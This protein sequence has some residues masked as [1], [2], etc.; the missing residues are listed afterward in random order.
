MATTLIIPL[1]CEPPYATGVALEKAKRQKKKK[2]KKKKK[3]MNNSKMMQN[4]WKEFFLKPAENALW[5]SGKICRQCFSLR[6]NILKNRIL[7]LKK[8]DGFLQYKKLRKVNNDGIGLPCWKYRKIV[9][10]V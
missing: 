9:L 10:C 3:K 1:A 7:P 4:E 5:M 6:M 2:K 8:S